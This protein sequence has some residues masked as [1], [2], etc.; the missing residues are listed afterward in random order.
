MERYQHGGNTWDRPDPLRWLDFS[1]NINPW[2]PPAEMLEAVAA[3]LPSINRYPDPKAEQATMAV[4]AY[5]Q[6]PAEN[7]LLTNGGL[8]G[9]ELLIRRLAPGAALI[10]QP[11]FVEYERLCRLQGIPTDSL[12]CWHEREHWQG[13]E[14]E[15]AQLSAGSLLLLCNPVNLTTEQVERL[16]QCLRA[17]GSRLL[18]DEAF[19]DF[20]PEHSVRSLALTDPDLLVAGSL[21]KLFAIPGL[22]LGYLVGTADL[23]TELR[24]QQTPWSVS[25]L[26]QAAARTVPALTDFVRDSLERIAGAKQ[27]LRDGLQQLGI[28]ALPSAANFLLLDLQPWQVTAAEINSRLTPERVQLRDCSNFVGLDPFYARAAVLRPEDNL[29]LIASLRSARSRCGT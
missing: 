18:V 15:L 7:L 1:A 20:A 19:I 8:G 28:R 12:L 2:G 22:R 27:E 23:I 25:L 13:P 11:G 5:L 10:C 3:A 4:A 26:A 21:T 9:L 24:S 14:A 29:R 6:V 17:T 16:L